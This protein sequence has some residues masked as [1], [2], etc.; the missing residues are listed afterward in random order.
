MNNVT[1]VGRLTKD[2]VLTLIKEE[3]KVVNFTLAVSRPYKNKDGEYDADFIQCQAWKG[4]AEFISSYIKKG[5]RIG[6]TGSWNTRTY[7]KEDGSTAFV[8]E[9]NVNSVESFE[10]R[11][12]QQEHNYNTVEE[13]KKAM[14]DEYALKSPGLSSEAQQNL[15]NAIAKKYQPMIDKLTPQ[16]LPF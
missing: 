4:Q 6:I 14:N 1:L 16:D 10:V 11:E 3:T 5:D 7:E 15:K 13:V 9:C 2:P 8:N 12:K